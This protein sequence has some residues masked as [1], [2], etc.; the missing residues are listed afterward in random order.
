LGLAP[1]LVGILTAVIVFVHGVPE[2]HRLWDRLRS[3]LSDESVAV[4][5]PGFGRERPSG[6]GATKDDYVDWLLGELGALEGPIDLVGHDWGA[7]FTFR[8]ATAHGDRIRSWAADVANIA[9]PDYVWHQ[10]AQTWQTSGE[11]EAS[12]KELLKAPAEDRAPLFEAMG[13]PRDDALAMVSALDQTMADCILN[14]YRSATPNPYSHWG[15]DFAV[16]KAPGL[17]LIP[18]ADPFGDDRMAT[19]VAD[20]LGARVE[21]LEGLGHWWP[22]QDPAAGAA[23]LKNFWSSLG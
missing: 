18:T 11:G 15:S 7:G 4:S 19:E 12:F 13:V 8:V 5:L 21:R 9:H 2:T 23:A 16:T 14:L 6:F 17:V 22:V 1:S 3:E 10:F 20:R